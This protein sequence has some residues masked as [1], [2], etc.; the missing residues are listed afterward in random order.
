MSQSPPRALFEADTPWTERYG[1]FLPL[2][3]SPL[4]AWHLYRFYAEVF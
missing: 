3:W 1:T 4:G 2:A